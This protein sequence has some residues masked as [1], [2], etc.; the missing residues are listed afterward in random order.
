MLFLGHE[1]RQAR[2]AEQSRQAQ[3][4][5]HLAPEARVVFLADIA[6]PAPRFVGADEENLARAVALQRHHRHESR[7]RGFFR[8]GVL[9]QDF[10]GRLGLEHS[11][12]PI[13]AREIFPDARIFVS[14]IGKTQRGRILASGGE[15]QRDRVGR[16]HAGGQAAALELDGEERLQQR[17]PVRVG[18]VVLAREEDD[19]AAESRDEVGDALHLLVVEEARIDVADDDDIV[20]HP[21]VLGRGQRREIGR[22]FLVAEFGIAL[23]EIKIRLDPLVAHEHRLKVAEFPARL[24]LDIKH[25]HFFVDD[26]HALRRLVVV[27]DRF[28]GQRGDGGLQ[29]IFALLLGLE[30]HRDDLFA[31][32]AESH[33]LAVHHLV[34]ELEHELGGVPLHRL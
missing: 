17:G 18:H 12:V 2:R 11:R 19:S 21:V 30:F 6:P 23:D 5:Q 22:I 33:V 3:P 9:E 32:V 25:L 29:F 31:V 15:F 10:R 28:V 8:R 34:A 13:D 26:P 1:L 24:L 20:L 16:G 7:A 14:I 27:L 4:Q